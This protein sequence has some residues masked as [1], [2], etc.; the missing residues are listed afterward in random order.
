MQHQIRIQP[1]T[2]R[3]YHPVAVEQ[4]LKTVGCAPANLTQAFGIFLRGCQI[5]PRRIQQRG[6][7]SALSRFPGNLMLQ[8]MAQPKRG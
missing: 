4:E 5:F 2:A 3:F 1:V 7:I 6:T 8:A